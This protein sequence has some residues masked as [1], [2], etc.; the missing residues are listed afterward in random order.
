[1]T[2]ETKTVVLW[3]LASG[4]LLVLGLLRGGPDVP[5]HRHSG[6]SRLVAALI[7][8]V[9][10]A[11][12]VVG[13][14]SGTLRSHLIQIAPLLVVVALVSSPPQWWAVAAVSVHSFWLV[15]MAGIW[16]FLLALSRFLSG[17]FSPTEVALTC[18]IGVAS[19]GGLIAA[20]S[21]VAQLSPIRR[22]PTILVTTGVQALA[23]WISYQPFVVGR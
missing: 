19:L 14:I 22:V 2:F 1:M 15:T 20:N 3:L 23:L 10:A 18:V 17:R 6:S 9:A 21:K 7:G 11:L 13:Y 4:L 5:E 16:L 8:V 12:L